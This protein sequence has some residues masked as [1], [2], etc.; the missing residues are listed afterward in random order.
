MQVLLLNVFYAHC[1]ACLTE[2]VGGGGGL[3]K[4]ESL[5]MA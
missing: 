4:E 2:N 1:G 5:V 3:K